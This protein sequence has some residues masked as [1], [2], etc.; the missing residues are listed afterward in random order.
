MA[1]TEGQSSEA[2][3]ST[4]P[5]ITTFNRALSVLSFRHHSVADLRV[6]CEL[7]LLQFCLC[8]PLR[9]L[10]CSS[11][12]LLAVYG[13][14]VSSGCCLS[15]FDKGM[16]CDI[17]GYWGSKHGLDVVD[18]IRHLL[19]WVCTSSTLS[20]PS[21]PNAS[22][23]TEDQQSF[24]SRQDNCRHS[25]KI[26][27]VLIGVIYDRKTLA[28]SARRASLPAAIFLIPSF[29]QRYGS[30]RHQHKG[31]RGVHVKLIKHTKHFSDPCWKDGRTSRSKWMWKE[32]YYPV[33]WTV[34]W[35]GGWQSG[36]S[37]SSLLLFC[38][39]S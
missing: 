25:S 9:H 16:Q 39:C 13:I 2:S 1:R 14:S 17:Q 11:T 36:E 34:L 6:I 26:S 24:T 35:P 10:A 38:I 31:S 15:R 29:P 5:T 27:Q 20:C 30:P 28:G 33:N 19:P 3:S 4:A 18:R 23:T 37:N 21:V 7:C 22:G 12:N 8:L 32:H